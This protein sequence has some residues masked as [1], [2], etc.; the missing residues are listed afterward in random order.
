[1]SGN[2]GLCHTITRECASERGVDILRIR[3]QDLR[4][5]NYQCLLYNDDAVY[6][7]GSGYDDDDDDDT[8][9]IKMM[10]MT[11]MRIQ[12]HLLYDDIRRVYDDDKDAL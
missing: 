6:D 3:R 1:M 9:I 11:M 12:T 8:T 2:Y 10:K 5:V 4:L 7:D